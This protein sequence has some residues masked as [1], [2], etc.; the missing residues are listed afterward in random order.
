MGG[1]GFMGECRRRLFLSTA[2]VVSMSGCDAPANEPEPTPE[3]SV[4]ECEEYVPEVVEGSH[5]GVWVDLSDQVILP[6]D[7]TDPGGGLVRVK[8]T[9]GATATSSFVRRRGAPDEE[10]HYGVDAGVGE[11]NEETFVFRAQGATSYDLILSPFISPADGD[12]SYSTEWKYEPI[13]DCY[14][15]NQTVETA[16][17]IPL[18]TP[19]V[20]YAHAGIVAGDG[21]MVGPSM[22]DFYRVELDEPT[23]VRL[24]FIKPDDDSLVVEFW[25]PEIEYGIV[26]V[27]FLAP[28]GVEVYSDE[29]ELAAGTHYIRLSP[30]VS[31]PSTWNVAEPL[32]PRWTT[33]YTLAVQTR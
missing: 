3:P 15:A 23:R 18:D 9:A 1:R 20:A 17:R 8:V 11:A 6:I 7:I 32:P 24:A 13:L 19:I 4:D 33:P 22:I 2:W 25:D 21:T 16:R 28:G 29:L 31:E 10:I 27:D 14:E 12:N 30:F 26:G 5:S